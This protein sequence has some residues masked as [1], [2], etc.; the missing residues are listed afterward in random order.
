MRKRIFVITLVV[1][2]SIPV[3]MMPV[4]WAQDFERRMEKSNDAQQAIKSQV[5]TDHQKIRDIDDRLKKVEDLSGRFASVE[6]IV[7][8]MDSAFWNMFFVFLAQFVAIIGGLFF[9]LITGKKKQVNP[10]DA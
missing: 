4:A 6:T 10:I 3:V 8:H 1:Y 2:F 9:W 5:D 7:Q